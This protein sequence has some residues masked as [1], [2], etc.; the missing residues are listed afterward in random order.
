[1]PYIQLKTPIPGPKSQELLARRAAAV[2]AALYQSVPIAYARASGSLVEDVDG[3]ILLD[4]VGGIGALAV[5][6]TP[7]QVTEAIQAQAEKYIHVCPIVANYEPYIE[8]C[9]QLNAITPGNFSKKTLLANGGAEAVENAVKLSRAYTKRAAIICFEGAYHG[10]SNL[11]MALTSK[12]GLFKKGFGPF[13][14]EIYRL[15]LPNLYRTPPGMSQDEYLEWSIWN[16]ENAL[17]AHVDPSAI[18]AILIEPIIGEGGFIPVPAP[19]LQKIREICDTY[20]IVMIADEIQCGFGRSGRLFAIEHSGVVPDLVITAKSLAAGTP[21]SAVTGRAEILDAPHLGGVGSTYGGNPLACVAALEAIKLINRPETLA[22]AARI[23][24]M[25]RSTFEPLQAEIP[26]LGDVRGR[27]AMMALEF[28]KDPVSK[29]PW[30]EFVIS[31]IQKCTTK[32]VLLLRAGLY[33]NCIR[34]LPQLDIPEAQ[35][36]EGLEIMAGSIVE[37]YREMR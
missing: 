13:A 30:P 18:A 14:P 3:N 9:E 36:R 15:P 19:F 33:S 12:Y 24:D 20:G 11:T 34:L 10:R 17:I 21:L 8:V 4:L 35:L 25:V 26:I 5:G 22:N 1:M 16:L 37:T 23:E 27:G 31:A 29:E 7:P 28:V 2:S 6:H 32:G